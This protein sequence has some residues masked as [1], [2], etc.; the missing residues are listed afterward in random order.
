MVQ[1]VEDTRLLCLILDEAH[2]WKPEYRF[3]DSLV[4]TGL[5]DD[6][7]LSEEQIKYVKK[8]IWKYRNQIEEKVIY[9][10]EAEDDIYDLLEGDSVFE[11]HD[12]LLEIF[13]EC[14]HYM[15]YEGNE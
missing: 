10:R 5:D 6:Q 4:S 11:K 9:K 14:E 1:N 3:I 13:N 12:S 7:K 15:N 8:S 2:Y